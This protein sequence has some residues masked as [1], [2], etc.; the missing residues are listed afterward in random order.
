MK[1]AI[2]G[3]TG[4][5]GRRVV[6]ELRSRGHEVWA[7]S[8]N[9]QKYRIDQKT[10][11]GLGAS[12]EGCNVIVDASNAASNA[13]DILVNG[14]RQLLAAEKAAGIGQH[15]CVSVVGCEQILISYFS[16]KAGRF[17]STP[18]CR[19]STKGRLYWSMN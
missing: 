12:L 14:S 16:V 18:F 17:N 19:Y 5:L 4:M 1:I 6:N 7:L 8:R 11:E 9:A 15:L 3:G 10:G 2:V 13:A